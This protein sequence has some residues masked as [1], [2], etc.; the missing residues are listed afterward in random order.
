MCE[1]KT[2]RTNGEIDNVQLEQYTS[3]F[4]LNN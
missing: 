1:A 2:D 3:T 4:P